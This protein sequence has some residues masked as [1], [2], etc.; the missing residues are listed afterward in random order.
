DRDRYDERS[1]G[2]DERYDDR[3]RREAPAYEPGSAATI[4][5]LRVD[6]QPPDASVY[7]DGEFRGTARQLQAL[8]LPAGRHRLGIV[9]PGYRTVERE[10]EIQP[11]HTTTLE[12]E[13]AR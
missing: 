7:V 6:A 10:V 2:R 1:E 3:G 13:L 4:G 11:G 5:T 9:R 12:A 8:S